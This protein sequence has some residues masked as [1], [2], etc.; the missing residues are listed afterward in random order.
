MGFNNMSSRRKSRSA[1]APRPPFLAP[2]PSVLARGHRRRRRR[3]RYLTYVGNMIS[4]A[5]VGCGWWAQGMNV[6]HER[7][8][9][10]MSGGNSS[11]SFLII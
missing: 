2:F 9:P 10:G 7:R 6:G 3:G 5:V 8:N 4:V 1:S 11:I